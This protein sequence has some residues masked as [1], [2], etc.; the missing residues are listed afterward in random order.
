MITDL[1]IE[2]IVDPQGDAMELAAYQEASTD[3]E[4]DRRIAGGLGLEVT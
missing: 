1:R 2:E 4:I 3:E